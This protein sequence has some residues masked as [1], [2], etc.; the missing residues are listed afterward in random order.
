M[1]PKK[2]AA[3]VA[4][5]DFAWAVDDLWPSQLYLPGV[6]DILTAAIGP[7]DPWDARAGPQAAHQILQVLPLTCL[8]ALQAAVA[9][10]V[11]AVAD[12]PCP[13]CPAL[14]WAGHTQ[15]CGRDARQQPTA[16]GAVQLVTE[17]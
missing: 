11:V 9:T 8:P 3:A 17:V 12:R 4:A 15:T 10:L 5:A 13:D 2:P 1:H 6:F 14:V 7:V 16:V